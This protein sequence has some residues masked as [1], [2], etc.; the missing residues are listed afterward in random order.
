MALS[1]M[2]ENSRNLQAETFSCSGWLNRSFE[3]MSRSIPS[4]IPCQ[5]YCDNDNDS[6]KSDE[7][8]MD[9][10][11]ENSVKIFLSA[12]RIIPNTTKAT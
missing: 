8:L 11:S 3:A 6:I 12:S 1:K 9:V 4:E 5:S 10:G 7:V 2:K